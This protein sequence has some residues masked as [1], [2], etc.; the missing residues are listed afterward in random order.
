MLEAWRGQGE[1][2][3]PLRWSGGNRRRRVAGDGPIPHSTYAGRLVEGGFST[4]AGFA[5]LAVGDL[6]EAK[7]RKGA[8][9]FTLDMQLWPRADR[10]SF[11]LR[12]GLLCPL[13]IAMRHETCMGIKAF[14]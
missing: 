14:T 5:G 1:S 9:F 12:P 3:G 7:M 11:V 2:E 4:D 8:V 13:V 10:C 6:T